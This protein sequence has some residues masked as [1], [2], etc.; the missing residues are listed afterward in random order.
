MSGTFPLSP[1][2]TGEPLISFHLPSRRICRHARVPLPRLD[3]LVGRRSI[4]P[5]PSPRLRQ[6]GRFL[7]FQNLCLAGVSPRH[8]PRR[9]NRESGTRNTAS[10][11]C[12]KRPTL[13]QASPPDVYLAYQFVFGDPR[14]ARTFDV[15]W[16]DS[17]RLEGVLGT[18]G[19]L[20]LVHP[21]DLLLD[22]Y[23][24]ATKQLIWRS[25]EPKPMNL[26]DKPASRQ[27][28]IDH[29]TQRLLKRYPPH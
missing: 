21:G 17:S 8:E 7:S 25:A 10:S 9:I 16:P 24:P 1:G 5:D 18:K 3:G 19:T 27:R 20:V 28:Q 23:D 13:A 29:A 2:I 6:A 22:F 15:E 14:D 11:S 12:K 4:R 26:D